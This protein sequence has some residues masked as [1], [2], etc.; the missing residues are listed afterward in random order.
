VRPAR[1]AETCVMTPISILLFSELEQRHIGF[2]QRAMFSV[3][4]ASLCHGD[5]TVGIARLLTFK[6][7]WVRDGQIF[8]LFPVLMPEVWTII[9]YSIKDS[10]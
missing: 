9:L 7:V 1:A 10:S 4:L 3:A 2:A 8:Q 6:I 5:Q